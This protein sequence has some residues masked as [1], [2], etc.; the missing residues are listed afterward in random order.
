MKLKT[1][2]AVLLTWAQPVATIWELIKVR[3]PTVDLNSSMAFTA[4]TPTRTANLQKQPVLH[5]YLEVQGSYNQ[6]LTV[7]MN[8][9]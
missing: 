4:R 2:M 8:H 6:A 5:L 3:V 1:F 7:A 9:L